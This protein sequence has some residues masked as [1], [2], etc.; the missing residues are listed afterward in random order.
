M[1]EILCPHCEEEIGLDDEASG[2]FSCPY[3]EGDFEWNTEPEWEAAEE[4][5]ERN[6]RRIQGEDVPPIP[7]IEWFGHGFSFF[8][9]IFMILCLTSGSYYSISASGSSEGFELTIVDYEFGLN[10]FSGESF[11][12]T[13]TSSYLGEIMNINLAVALTC[14]ILPE[15]CSSVVRDSE[16]EVEFYESWNSAGNFLGFFLILA[17]LSSIAVFAF[18]MYLFLDLLNVVAFN[19]RMYVVS[20]YGK[21]F[22]PFVIGGLLLIGMILFMLIS[23]GASLFEDLISTS[24]PWADLSSGFGLIVWSS[25]LVSIFYPVFSIFEMNAE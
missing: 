18:R 11:G 1:V 20:T 24:L 21:L 10:S 12:E 4:I 7:P 5:S 14:D 6:N 23:P 25:L 8:M 19:E 2:E 15:E 9:V 3:C 17:L 13:E 22:L 16:N